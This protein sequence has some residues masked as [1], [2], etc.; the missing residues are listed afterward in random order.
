MRKFSALLAIMTFSWS[1]PAQAGFEFMPG[2]AK[3]ERPAPAPSLPMPVARVMPMGSMGAVAV[4]A[5][6][7]I[8]EPLTPVGAPAM[9]PMVPVAPALS[10]APMIQPVIPSA[11]GL[12]I[13]PYPLQAG[14]RRNAFGDVS[15]GSINRALIEEAALVTPMPLGPDMQTGANPERV[16]PK[17]KPIQEQQVAAIAPANLVPLPG[18]TNE[19]IQREFMAPTTNYSDAV[20]FGKE[21]P[22]SIALSQVVPE[23]FNIQLQDKNLE[24]AIVSW[25]GGRPWN[26]VL[27]TML[28]PLGYSASIKG[29]A[30]AITP[31]MR[32]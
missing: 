4:P 3:V 1:V 11:S 7:V 16:I 31:G 30:V 10:S 27:N 21:I 15:S 14:E 29:N 26:E 32:G 12:L 13:N 20:G 6:P 8:S 9:Q 17:S 24:N 5:A 25:E 18:L 23:S 28:T 2:Q 22:L 19:P